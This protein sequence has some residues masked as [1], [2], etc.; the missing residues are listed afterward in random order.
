MKE[1]FHPYNFERVEAGAGFYH[2][3]LEDSQSGADSSAEP[4]AVG[5]KGATIRIDPSDSCIGSHR[6]FPWIIETK[7]INFDAQIVPATEKST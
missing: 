7:F 4:F 5:N 6:H 3:H 1:G 2:T